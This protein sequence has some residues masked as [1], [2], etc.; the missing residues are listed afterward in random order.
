MLCAPLYGETGIGYETALATA[1]QNFTDVIRVAWPKFAIND[2]Y[3]TYQITRCEMFD[4]LSRNCVDFS[5]TTNALLATGQLEQFDDVTDLERGTRYQYTINACEGLGSLNCDPTVYPSIAVSAIGQI[6]LDDLFENDDTPGQAYEVSESVTQERSLGT[7][8]DI[9]WVKLILSETQEIS[10]IT[11]GP[12]NR[13]TEITIFDEELNELFYNDN[14]ENSDTAFAAITIPTI[15]A[16]TYF[17]KVN[18]V[19]DINP[20]FNRAI[21]NYTLEIQFSAKNVLPLSA[22]MLLLD[23]D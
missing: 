21:P 11:S 22:I 14:P 3:S 5:Y 15:P 10:V 1:T 19:L 13:D 17:L 23:E 2:L 18:Q 4:S 6:G 20:F 12:S 9:D 8:D 7:A 16:G